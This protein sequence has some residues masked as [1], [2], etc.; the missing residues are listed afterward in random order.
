MEHEDHMILVTWNPF[1]FSVKERYKSC[2]LTIIFTWN[3]SRYFEVY[4]H[5]TLSLNMDSKATPSGVTVALA[6]LPGP[7]LKRPHHDEDKPTIVKEPSKAKKATHI[8]SVSSISSMN[9]VA[10]LSEDPSPTSKKP[11]STR[12]PHSKAC[13]SFFVSYHKPQFIYLL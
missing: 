7:S 3:E 2:I 5:T 10:Q 9:R 13:V 1:F 12:K 6:S 11:S 4:R 8:R